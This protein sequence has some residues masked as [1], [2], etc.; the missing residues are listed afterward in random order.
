MKLSTSQLV[1]VVF[2]PV[3][4]YV[5]PFYIFAKALIKKWGLA[6]V[7]I[8]IFLVVL[9]LAAAGRVVPLWLNIAGTIG[10]VAIQ[11]LLF[12]TAL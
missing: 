7:C 9:F 11:Q 2:L 1:G 6:I 3:I 12:R 10:V 5:L 8:A 4:V